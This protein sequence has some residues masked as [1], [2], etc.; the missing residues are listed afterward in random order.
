MLFNVMVH[1]DADDEQHIQDVVAG[2]VLTP[3]AMIQNISAAFP[4]TVDPA[5][6]PVVAHDG[7]VHKN[8]KKPFTPP[9]LP[10]PE[11]EPD[12]DEP[13]PPTVASFTLTPADPSKGDTV[14]FDGSAS[15]GAGALSY[16]W[17]FGDGATMTG[18]AQVSYVY[19]GKGDYLATLVITDGAE[20]TDE[21]S[22]TV[23]VS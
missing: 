18:G 20:Q 3:G 17:D 5:E 16:A 11:P 14:D 13:A 22:Q 6:L 1:V 7:K 15:T 2:W 9:P 8:P 4:V 19:K 21:A 10:E 23:T 12:P